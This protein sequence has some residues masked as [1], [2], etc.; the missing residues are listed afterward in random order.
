MPTGGPRKA[1]LT[2]E[3]SSGNVFLGKREKDMIHRYT[4]EVKELEKNL[5]AEQESTSSLRMTL[6]E[7]KAAISK[8]EAELKALKEKGYTP[9]APP[10]P[11]PDSPAK[12]TGR[13]SAVAGRRSRLGDGSRPSTPLKATPTGEFKVRQRLQPSRLARVLIVDDDVMV[14]RMLTLKLSKTFECLAAKDGE[15]ALEKF[16]ASPPDVMLL[17]IYMPKKDGYEVCAEIRKVSE[18]PIVMMTAMEDLDA[19][20]KGLFLGADDFVVKPCYPKEV[21][22]RLKT[23]LRRINRQ[24]EVQVYDMV[25][26][27]EDYLVPETPTGEQLEDVAK[28]IAQSIKRFRSVLSGLHLRGMLA[29]DELQSELQEIAGLNH[30]MSALLTASV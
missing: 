9:A 3:G 29:E 12:V 18:V 14:R 2:R 4:L 19:R 5:H 20:L 17:D 7:E 28:K 23:M 24:S 27:E 11:R 16:Y 22:A 13:T 21:E 15:E 26:N 1:A 6:S 30:S 8:L 25:M 10:E